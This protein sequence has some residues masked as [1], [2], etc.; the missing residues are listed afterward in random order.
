MVGFGL[1]GSLLAFREDVDAMLFPSLHY[2]HHPGDPARVPLERVKETVEAAHPDRRLVALALPAT[3]RRAP[4]ETY[5]LWM[6]Q[7]EPDS[8]VYLFVY[9]DPVDGRILGARHQLRDPIWFLWSLHWSLAELSSVGRR[10]AGWLGFVILASMISGLVLFWPMLKRGKGVLPRGVGGRRGWLDLH[11]VV[12]FWTWPVMLLAT[13]T[14]IA[15]GLSDETRWIAR[16]VADAPGWPAMPSV[17]AVDGPNLTLDELRAIA[18]GAVPD[19]TITTVG[20]PFRPGG[21]ARVGFMAPGDLNPWGT[22]HV[23]LHPVTGQVL[24]IR[25]PRDRTPADRFLGEWLIALHGGDILGLP[26][27]VVICLVGI[28]PLVGL[29]SGIVLWRRGHG[30]G[31]RAEVPRVAHPLSRPGPS[32]AAD[33]RV[34]PNA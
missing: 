4:P 3:R 21:P 20:P 13:L 1:T 31:G 8:P 10:L 27:R 32:P 22:G 2:S 15:I 6:R 26:G 5:M 29:V 17:D 9:V 19:T 24:A 33:D 11:T 30:R 14:G 18:K 16:Q 28:A 12:G 25:D 34:R 7:R 23:L